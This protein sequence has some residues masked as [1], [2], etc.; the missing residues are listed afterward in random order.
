MAAELVTS[1]QVAAALHVGPAAV[2]KY[3]RGGRIPFVT[4]PGG[5]RR[6]D[7]VAVRQALAAGWADDQPEVGSVPVGDGEIGDLPPKA[8]VEVEADWAGSTRVPAGAGLAGHEW[9][10]LLA[11]DGLG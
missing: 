1:E 5:H 3:A 4:T 11:D 6:Y 9:A 7:L 8:V 10:V 2:R